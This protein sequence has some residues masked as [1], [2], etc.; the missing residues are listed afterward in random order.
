MERFNVVLTQS[1]KEGVT[2]FLAEAL[3]LG[4][5]NLGGLAIDVAKFCKETYILI[6]VDLKEAGLKG[7]EKQRI[8]MG[9]EMNIKIEYVADEIKLNFYISQFGH[10]VKDNEVE[11]ISGVIFKIA[12]YQERFGSIF[13]TRK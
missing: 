12:D 9:H 10:F 11:K 8:K 1:N 13:A 3:G 2:S 6:N 4:A 7:I 5:E